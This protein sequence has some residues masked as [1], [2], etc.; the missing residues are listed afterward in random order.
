[1]PQKT[2]LSL[3]I[4]LGQTCL[5]SQT[6]KDFFNRPGL[7]INA[8]HYGCCGSGHNSAYTFAYESFHCGEDVLT[9]A[10]NDGRGFAYLAF[11]GYKV[12]IIT[13]YCVK[14]LYYDF[15]LNVGDTLQEGFYEHENLVVTETS[16]ITLLNGEERRKVVLT[17]GWNQ[18]V[19]WV[20]GIGDLD[21]GLYPE[22]DYE[23]YDVFVCAAD[24]SG[25]IWEN[26]EEVH[27]CEYYNCPSPRPGFDVLQND[28]TVTLTNTSLFAE[29]YS[30]EFGDGTVASGVNQEYTYSKAGCYLL[31]LVAENACYSET[32]STDFV[33]PVCIGTDWDPLDTITQLPN[34]QLKIISP[35][36]RFL[37]GGNLLYRSTD[38]GISWQPGTIPAA[39][40][41]VT[42]FI[43]DLEMYDDTRGI[44]VLGH[45]GASSTEEAVLI[46]NNGGATWEERLPGSYFISRLE[47]GKN[48]KAWMSGSY[49][50]YVS[51][52]YG[53]TWQEF[54]DSIFLSV[55]D[56][57]N[58]GDSL[59]VAEVYDYLQPWGEYFMAKS[60]DGGYNW[61]LFE[62]PETI[63]QL[64]FLNS[65]IGFGY[66]HFQPGLYKTINGGNT[67]SQIDPNV[68]VFDIAF[69]NEYAGWIADHNGA[70]Y[71]TSDAMTTFDLTNCAKDR[72]GSLNPLSETTVLGISKNKLFSYAGPA[73]FLCLASDQD[74]DGYSDD[75]DCDDTDPGINPGEV[76]IP[77]NGIDENCDGEDLIS[78]IVELGTS[79]IH[80]YPNPARE[81]LYFESSHA[82]NF[83][84]SMYTSVGELVLEHENPQ[85]FSLNTLS[86]GL[87]YILLSDKVQGISSVAKIIVT[88]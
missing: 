48:G 67:W 28:F 43:T 70:V 9:F 84:A 63:T 33:L 4:L 6:T 32:V 55:Y 79:I 62:L 34:A 42:R 37:Y 14:T 58:L 1:M 68:E 53:N 54:S 81:I 23:G 47:L 7:S 11:D 16:M 52:D 30:W 56:F 71:F 74:L 83:N 60:W 75:A 2:I 20:E 85:S 76:E 18:I 59:L 38:G 77:D 57:Q 35:Q 82:T 64:Y 10:R 22:M 21:R 40:A 65:T 51:E 45:Y 86:P 25:N 87:Y 69:Y 12:Y 50:Y 39:P 19:T 13:S 73:A 78:E 24:P 5:F 66:H 27:Q 15:G 26:P 31:K 17:G 61:Q 72:I 3:L 49:D 8:Y 88:R 41:G 29:N 46:T 36:L 44:I 80:I